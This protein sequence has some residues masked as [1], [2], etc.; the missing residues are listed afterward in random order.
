M[1]RALA[2]ACAIVILID[3]A[4]WIIAPAKSMTELGLAAIHTHKNTLGSAM[5]LSSMLIAPYALRRPTLSGRALWWAIWVASFLL[6]VASRSKTSIAI[7]IGVLIALPL[8]AGIL[9]LNLL[10]LWTVG[11]VF[12][13]SL[14]TALFA[15]T[16]YAFLSGMDPLDPVSHLT[17]T[18]RTDVWRFSLQ[19]GFLHPFTGVG[20]GSFWD[21]DP[22]VQPSLQTDEWFAKPDAYTNESHNGYIDLFVTTGVIGL[23]GALMLLVRWILGGLKLLRQAKEAPADLRAYFLFVAIFPLLFFA[24]NFM[25]S[26]YFTANTLFGAMILLVG[27]DIEMTSVHSGPVGRSLGRRDRRAPQHAK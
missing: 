19:Q 8:L 23:A 12:A 24:H 5:L 26:S 22:G 13:L 4:S 16:I 21:V 2:M 7:A 14:A 27:I 1:H 3:F 20:F 15:W 18:K 25:E 6:L 11:L 10:R 9:R 17:F